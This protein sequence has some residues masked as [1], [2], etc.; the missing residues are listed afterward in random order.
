MVQAQKIYQKESRL[1][2]FLKGI[3]W[4]MIAMVDT[5]VVALLVTWILLGA[6]RFEESGWIMLIETPLKLLIYYAHE[7]LW[8]YV[9]RNHE[10]GNR[11]IIL[12]T[13][14]WRVFA[15][16]MTFV[17]AY[18]IFGQQNEANA[19]HSSQMMA[20]VALAISITE[21]V[22]KTVLYY[23]HEKLWLRVQLGQVR[24]IYRRLKAKLS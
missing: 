22:S 12:K 9:W 2:S 23:F 4:R 24:R 20:S 11:E 15:T 16:G 18:T 1:R 19:A 6:P 17:I 13:I 10:V 3:S 8:Q 14:S 5:F 21:L 7:R